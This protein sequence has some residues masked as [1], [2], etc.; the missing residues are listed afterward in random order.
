VQDFNAEIGRREQQKNDTS[1]ITHAARRWCKGDEGWSNWQLI[2]ETYYGEKKNDP[3]FQ[4]VPL[5]T[6]PNKPH[7]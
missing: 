6:N 3:T 7:E 1:P 5:D 2:S 4:F